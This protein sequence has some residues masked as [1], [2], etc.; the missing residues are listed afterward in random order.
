MCEMYFDM[1]LHIE[2]AYWGLTL[3]TVIDQNPKAR[4]QACTIHL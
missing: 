2:W 1:S 3:Q 4:F